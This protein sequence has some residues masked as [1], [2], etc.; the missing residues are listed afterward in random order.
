MEKPKECRADDPLR[1]LQKI[2][3]SLV[4]G[5]HALGSSVH[6]TLWEQGA[7][8]TPKTGRDLAGKPSTCRSLT[9]ACIIFASGVDKR[10][11]AVT[12][13][14]HRLNC[15]APTALRQ[16]IWKSCQLGMLKRSSFRPS[17]PS[18]STF[19][20][21]FCLRT[22]FSTVSLHQISRP[23]AGPKAPPK[24]TGQ[25]ARH[26]ERI[27]ARPCLRLGLLSLPLGFLLL[28]SHLLLLLLGLLF[29]LMLLFSFGF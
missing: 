22:V 9:E 24:Q 18:A 6:R 26:R 27:K 5:G 19:T 3:C 23:A 11:A 7:R 10:L 4:R 17:A 14:G 16:L 13:T 20:D 21:T 28:S 8:C 2:S 12:K 29:L 25:E 15:D 1:E